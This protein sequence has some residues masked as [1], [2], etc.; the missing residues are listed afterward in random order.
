MMRVET[1]FDKV[2]EFMLIFG[3][4]GYTIPAFPPKPTVDLRVE[5][6]EEEVRELKKAIAD[7]DIVEVA[8][9]LTDILYVVYGAGHAFGIELDECFYEVH[10]SNLS[11]LG[12]DGNPIYRGDGKVVKGPN[13]RPPDLKSVILG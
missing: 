13:Y 9:A 8:D 11:K 10:E 3:Q 7:N 5:L 4:A 12:P 2:G 6:I 1:N